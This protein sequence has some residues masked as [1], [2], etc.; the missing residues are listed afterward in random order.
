MNIG[1]YILDIDTS[2]EKQQ[3]LECINNLCNLRKQDNIVLFNNQFNAVDVNQKYYILHINQAKFFNGVLFVDGTRP[4]LLT[5]SFPCP[6]K[7]ILYMHKAEWTERTD[8]PFTVWANVY[9]NPNTS[10]LTDNFDTYN[11]MRICWKEPLPLLSAFNAEE[12][13]HVIQTL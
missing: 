2:K 11:L 7:Q 12:I 6:S 9:L 1:F 13:N 3:M 8:L 5:N 10:L 4:A